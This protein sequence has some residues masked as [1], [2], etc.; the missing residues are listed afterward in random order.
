M[1]ETRHN[2]GHDSVTLDSNLNELERLHQFIDT[3]CDRED[4]SDELRYHLTL[5]LEEL[6]INAIT[7]GSCNPQEGAIR[8]TMLLEG[9]DVHVTF[10]DTG[11]AF[12]PLEA[13]PPDLS[14]DVLT[15]SIGGLGIHLVRSLIPSIRYE[16]QG[17]RNYLFLTRQM[18]GSEQRTTTH[19]ENRD[20]NR[21]GD[22]PH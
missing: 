6:V 5:A 19:Q 11:I 3:F 15:R 12:N 22:H 17:D 4:V 10:S 2:S 7:H 20:A 9:E 13:P 18:N 21:D 8:L 14:Q 16:R 1:P